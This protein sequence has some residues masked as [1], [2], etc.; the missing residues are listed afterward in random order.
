MS[1]GLDGSG[2]ACSVCAAR[3]RPGLTGV[4]ESPVLPS[5]CQEGLCWHCPFLAQL[6][7]SREQAWTDPWPVLLLDQSPEAQVLEQRPL[8][9]LVSVRPEPLS[10]ACRKPRDLPS[11]PGD[12]F[13][14][15][16]DGQG[17]RLLMCFQVL[18]ASDSSIMGFRIPLRLDCLHP[19]PR[20]RVPSGSCPASSSRA[21]CTKAHQPPTEALEKVGILQT[22][23]T[24]SANHGGQ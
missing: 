19:C 2:P 5:D 11:V 20:L 12:L 8:A 17:Q 4:T 22:S 1:V 15:G 24:V 18:P 21:T 23:E 3:C 16:G 13:V 9:F 14:W 6:R 7:P 10:S